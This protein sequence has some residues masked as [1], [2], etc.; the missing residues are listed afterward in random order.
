MTSYGTADNQLEYY[1]QLYQTVNNTV[2]Y[3]QYS[4]DTTGLKLDCDI[5]QMRYMRVEYSTVDCCMRM[6][7]YLG[8]CKHATVVKERAPSNDL[9]GP[10]QHTCY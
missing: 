6:G 3:T 5:L 10:T 7:R 9:H 8:E 2:K 1:I 4:T